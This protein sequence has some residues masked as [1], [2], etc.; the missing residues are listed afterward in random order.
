MMYRGNDDKK[1]VKK[2]NRLTG[3]AAV[4]GLAGF[5]SIYIAASTDDARM[6]YHDKTVASEKTTNKML[7]GGAASL[8]GAI[9]LLQIRDRKYPGR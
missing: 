2:R 8:I 4:L 7:A 6:I 3:W 1:D 5:M 9:A